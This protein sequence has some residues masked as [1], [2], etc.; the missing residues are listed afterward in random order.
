MQAIYALHIPSSFSY[1]HVIA[2][3]PMGESSRNHHCS[4]MANPNMVTCLD[5]NADRQSS[6]STRKKKTAVS[7]KQPSNDSPSVSKT[8]ATDVPLGWRSLESQGISIEA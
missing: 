5:K 1:Q 8:G 2:E 7:S 3:D 4:E 6:T